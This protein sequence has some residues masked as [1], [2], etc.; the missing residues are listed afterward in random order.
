MQDNLSIVITMIIFVVLVVIFPLYNLFERQDDMSYNLA[1]KATTSFVDEIVN[2]GYIDQTSY[3]NYISQ[4][5]NT[6]NTYD[7]QIEAHRKMLIDDVS[8]ITIADDYIE[9]YKIDYSED[10]LE[11]INSNTPN[12]TGSISNI[13]NAYLL[14][15]DDQIYIKLKNSNTTMAGAIFNTIIPTAKK[16]RIVVNYGGIVKNSSWKKIESTVH[17]YALKPPTPIVTQNGHEIPGNTMEVDSGLSIRFVATSQSIGWWEKIVS[18]HWTFEYGNETIEEQTTNTID[19]DV[20]G[21]I[22]RSFPVE[23]PSLVKVYAVDVDGKE[24]DVAVITVNTRSIKP[25]LTVT[26]NPD[27]IN[28]N[29][30]LPQ[31]GGTP[32]TFTGHGVASGGK[33]ISEY[34]W[35]IQ[36][37]GVDEAPVH[38]TTGTFSKTFANGNA[39]V[40]VYAVDSVGLHSDTVI[41]VFMIMANFAESTITG[42]GIA[43]IDSILVPGATISSYSFEVSIRPE[44]RG[45][46][47]WKIQGLPASGGDWE[48]INPGGT[49]HNDVRNGVTT[50]RIT[51]PDPYKYKQLKFQYSVDTGH[52]GCL[53]DNPYIKYSVQYIFPPS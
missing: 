33:S 34:V 22:T 49:A 9:Q 15:Q 28:T 35:T 29:V 27:T 12:I 13:T 18:Y 40:K 47:W 11:T 24:S 21:T 38:T 36:N 32:V 51:L 48:N 43:E 2:N 4:L 31:S 23:T 46:D 19:P 44:H 53:R 37:N 5:G 20:T 3:D 26:S 25:T 17:S 14:N 39:I 52:L 1:L 41:I 7:V 6:G 10:I 50:G 45:D 30:V 8:T 16:E 42:V